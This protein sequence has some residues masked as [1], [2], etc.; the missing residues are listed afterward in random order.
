MISRIKEI[1]SGS[2]MKELQGQLSAMTAAVREQSE[3]LAAMRKESEELRKSAVEAAAEIGK[4]VDEAK[5]LQSE[6]NAGMAELK[7]LST[8]IQSSI[9]QKI[10]DEILGLTREVKAKLEG[11]ERLKAEV[12]GTAAAVNAELARLK[13][14]IA[15]LADVAGKIKAEDFEL[16][17]FA[18]QLQAA[19]NEKLQLMARIDSLE[20]LI[21]KM[22]RDR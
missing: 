14:D 15:R 7:A 3:G 6:L 21:A 19:D 18:H 9:K 2:E 4:A 11:A 5:R 8:H 13:A 22:R 1:V 10:T 20:R 16:T 17:K 12:A